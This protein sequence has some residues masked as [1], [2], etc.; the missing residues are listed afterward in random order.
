MDRKIN[1]QFDPSNDY[2]TFLIGRPV[3]KQFADYEDSR[4]Q[5]LRDEASTMLNIEK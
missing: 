1:E 5:M 3:E 4:L 2:Y